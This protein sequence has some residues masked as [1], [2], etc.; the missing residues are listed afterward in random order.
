VVHQIRDSLKHV[1]SKNQKEFM[2][3]LKT[4]YQASSK[5]S[6]EYNLLKPDDKRGKKYPMVIKS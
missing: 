3:D 4:V 5:D 1:A 6:A 2:V